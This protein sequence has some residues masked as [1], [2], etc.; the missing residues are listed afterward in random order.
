M[1]PTALLQGPYSRQ[2]DGP[3]TGLGVEIE[4]GGQ[5]ARGSKARAR[6]AP[7][8]MSVLERPPNV[9]HAG[10]MVDG[11][12]LESLERVVADGLDHQVAAITVPQHVRRELGC[13]DGSVFRQYLG[14]R[15]RLRHL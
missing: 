4:L 15:S 3:E 2:D 13:H 5:P 7:R 10:T 8:R 6:R 9:A 1:E 12:Q 11:Q 14:H